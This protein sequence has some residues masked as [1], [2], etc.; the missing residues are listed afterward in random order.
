MPLSG[1]VATHKSGTASLT[2]AHGRRGQAYTANVRIR[3]PKWPKH[4]PTPKSFAR[5]QR[6]GPQT[7]R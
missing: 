5:T 7:K 6:R 1:F 2:V 4:V 3:A